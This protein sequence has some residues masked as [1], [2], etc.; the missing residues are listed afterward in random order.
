MTSARAEAEAI[1]VKRE[2]RA[3]V[4]GLP[5]PEPVPAADPWT[6]PAGWPDAAVPEGSGEAVR[7][8]RSPSD[9]AGGG[10]RRARPEK[11]P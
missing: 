1:R 2:L 11:T 8:S 4:A 5:Q 9:A 3:W 10:V 7:S 6:P